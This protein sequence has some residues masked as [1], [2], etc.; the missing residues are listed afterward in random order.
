MKGFDKKHDYLAHSTAC[1]R[2]HGFDCIINRPVRDDHR[3]PRG[4]V[5]HRARHA[6]AGGQMDVIFKF[7]FNQTVTGADKQA[8][9][10]ELCNY[11][12]VPSNF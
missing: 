10:E 6:D 4:R 5:E 11:L 8:C 1:P 12:G 3:R 9:I 7:L 2:R